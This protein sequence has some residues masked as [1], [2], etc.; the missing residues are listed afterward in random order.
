MRILQETCMCLLVKLWEKLNMPATVYQCTNGRLSLQL[1][2][3]TARSSSW[4]VLLKKVYQKSIEWMVKTDLIFS[5]IVTQI[6]WNGPRFSS[7]ST[8]SFWKFK[9]IY[10]PV[11]STEFVFRLK[12]ALHFL[13]TKTNHSYSNRPRAERLVQCMYFFM[14]YFTFFLI[15]EW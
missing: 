14:I 4:S 1:G 10:S 7:N 6:N 9:K 12:F 15:I 3:V 8:R 2:V 13:R 11:D 5:S